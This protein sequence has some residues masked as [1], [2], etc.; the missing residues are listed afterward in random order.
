MMGLDSAQAADLFRREPDR[1]LDVGTGEVA[2][3]VAGHGPDVLFV[4]GWPVSGAT[5]RTLLPHLTDHVTC[6][7][8]D[9]PGTGSSRHATGAP[10]SISTHIDAVRRTLDLLGLDDV[11]VVGHDSG[12]LIARHALAGDPRLRA[13]GLIDTEMST[14]SSW[15][16]RTFLAGRKV[17]GFGAALGWLAGQ[18]RLR[19]SRLVLGDAFADPSHLDGEFDELFLQ[20]LHR[21]AE[22]REANM[23]ILRT[24]DYRFVRELAGLHERI[25]VP[26][27]LVWGEQDRFFPIDRAE[28]MVAEFDDARL[29]RIAGAG[30]FAHEERPADV[31]RALLPTITATSSS[32]RR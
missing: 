6:H 31:A 3:R 23:R 12:G 7:L 8:I 22:H 30:L 16:F 21:S 5:F 1:F 11:A 24:F 4:H 10:L 19:R 2:H 29:V 25:R 27:V 26:V 18:P 32:A 14:G 28:R 13:M 17:P 9:L 15:K 20:P